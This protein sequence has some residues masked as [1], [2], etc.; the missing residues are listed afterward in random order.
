MDVINKLEKLM[1][2]LF[3]DG[4]ALYERSDKPRLKDCTYRQLLKQVRR[5]QPGGAQPGTPG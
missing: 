1:Q 5:S 4:K 3:D 2:H